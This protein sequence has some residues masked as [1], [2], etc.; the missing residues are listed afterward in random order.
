M[1]NRPFRAKKPENGAGRGGE[2]G[3]K[4]QA[5]RA[6][7]GKIGADLFAEPL[8]FAVSPR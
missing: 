5:I 1:G 3:K 4:N 8:P 6:E 7:N 2:G